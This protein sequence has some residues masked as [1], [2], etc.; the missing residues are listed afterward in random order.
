MS[1]EQNIKT[2]QRK[3]KTWITAQTS[4]L[5]SLS[6]SLPAEHSR[7][8][9]ERDALIGQLQ[10]SKAGLCQNVEDLKKQQEEESK[11]N[12]ILKDNR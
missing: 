10:R 11:V 1:L 12:E 8:L 2:H 9:E 7:R 4:S 5:S 3:F 6:V